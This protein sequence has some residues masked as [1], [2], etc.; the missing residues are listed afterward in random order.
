MPVIR[1]LAGPFFVCAGVM[2]FVAPRVYRRIVPP[3]VPAPT[4]MVYASGVAEIAGGV[5][6]VA[7]GHRR[8]AGWWL[9]ATLLAVFPANVHMAQHPDEFPQVPGGAAGLW[10]RLPVQG[11]FIAWVLSAMRASD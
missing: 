7:S 8:V 3:Y 1:R 10:A 9:I 11:V 5:G 6:L 2:H 4:A